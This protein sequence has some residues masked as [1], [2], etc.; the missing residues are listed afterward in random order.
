MA[1]R[2][3]WAT[4]ST[5]WRR[6][7]IAAR[8][9]RRSTPWAKSPRRRR[10]PRSN[11]WWWSVADAEELLAHQDRPARFDCALAAHAQERAIGAV[12]V[13]QVELA[14]A[15]LEARVLPRPVAVI[16]KQGVAVLAGERAG[17]AEGRI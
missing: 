12:E 16:G 6:S 4:A 10:P 5:T 13:G 3:R 15:Q 8:S 11:R 1:R 17:F 9:T 7:T 14:V 2:S